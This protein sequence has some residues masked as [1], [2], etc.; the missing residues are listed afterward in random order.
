MNISNEIANAAMVQDGPK[1]TLALL[2]RPWNNLGFELV[3]FHST[4]HKRE[5]R[6]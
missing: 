6:S 4:K 3:I 2:A 5:Q 1:L